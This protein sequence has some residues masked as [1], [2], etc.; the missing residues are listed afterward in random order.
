MPGLQDATRGHADRDVAIT[1]WVFWEADSAG[2]GLVLRGAAAAAVGRGGKGDQRS[3][4]SQPPIPV[5]PRSISDLVKGH[6]RWVN[7]IWPHCQKERV[8]F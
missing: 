4:H 6:G 2:L 5:L 8:P 7:V 1:D 3:C